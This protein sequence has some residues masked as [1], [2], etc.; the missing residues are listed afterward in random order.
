MKCRNCPNVV[1]VSWRRTHCK[2]LNNIKVR[3]NDECHNNVNSL[4]TGM[5]ARYERDINIKSY[6]IPKKKNYNKHFNEE[7]VYES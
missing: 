4:P 2:L 1:R 5:L 6:V 7:V 3:L